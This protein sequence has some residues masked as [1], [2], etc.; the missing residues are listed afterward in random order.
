M[1]SRNTAA[2]RIRWASGGAAV[3]WVR[4]GS[5]SQPLDNDALAALIVEADATGIAAPFGWPRRFVAAVSQ[6]DASSTWPEPWDHDPRRA[7]G[8]EPPTVD[9]PNVS[10]ALL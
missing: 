4:L 8:L 2:C 7:C 1:E 10:A 9:W 3:D 6:S 5:E